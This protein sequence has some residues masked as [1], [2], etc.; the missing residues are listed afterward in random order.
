M[1]SL[2]GSP[3]PHGNRNGNDGVL[4]LRERARGRGRS[5]TYARALREPSRLREVPCRNGRR[6]S[7]SSPSRPIWRRSRRC[8]AGAY[9]HHVTCRSWDEL[10]RKAWAGTPSIKTLLSKLVGKGIVIHDGANE[11]GVFYALASEKGE[12]DQATLN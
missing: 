1:N 7:A 9:R 6:P 12:V 2:G 8:V 3:N 5:R 11:H 10:T 4:T